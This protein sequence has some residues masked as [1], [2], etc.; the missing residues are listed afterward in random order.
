MG[1]HPRHASPATAVRCCAWTHWRCPS[2]STGWAPASRSALGIAHL[3]DVVIQRA[4]APNVVGKEPTPSRATAFVCDA[5]C[6]FNVSGLQ[7]TLLNASRL[8]ST[9]SVTGNELTHGQSV[10]IPPVP[11]PTRLTPQADYIQ[12][13]I[14]S[15]PW[16]PFTMRHGLQG[17]WALIFPRDRQRLPGEIPL[18]R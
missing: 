18:I 7:G 9:G 15:S 3:R 14:T 2:S 16:K 10:S 1:E 6:V 8:N 5:M 4:T 17:Q 11:N 13:F 12:D